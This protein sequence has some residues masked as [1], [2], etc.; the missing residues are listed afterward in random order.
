MSLPV[1][2]M[3]NLT[4]AGILLTLAGLTGVIYGAGVNLTAMVARG[5]ND[6]SFISAYIAEWIF[7]LLAGLVLIASGVKKQ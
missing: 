5:A 6:Y 4:V 1:K 3:D 7:V 2:D